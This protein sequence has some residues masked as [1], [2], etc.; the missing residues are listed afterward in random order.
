M[1]WAAVLL[2]G[3][4][5][6]MLRQVVY[7]TVQARSGRDFPIGIL[8]VNLTGAFLLGVA[9][10]AELGDR[11]PAWLAVGLQAGLLGAYTTYS[12]W[13]VDSLRLIRERRPVAV[14][15][16]LAGALAAGVALI[17]VGRLV[18]GLLLS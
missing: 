14:A 17:A 1:I 12:T 5:G 16:N 8:A 3:S 6:A 10:G 13:G 18:G 11:V 2:G 4:I 9:S 7:G 15:M